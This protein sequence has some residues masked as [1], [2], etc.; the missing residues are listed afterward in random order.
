MSSKNCKKN[1]DRFNK[2]QEFL[3][4]TEKKF[5]YF[6]TRLYTGKLVFWDYYLDF[7]GFKIET[8]VCPE[9]IDFFV[10]AFDT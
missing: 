2:R 7:E 4:R 10:A 3:K 5:A 8:D 6:P 9:D 1:R